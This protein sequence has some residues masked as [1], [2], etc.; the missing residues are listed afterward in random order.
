MAKHISVLDIGTAKTVVIIAEEKKEVEPRRVNVLGFGESKTEGMKNGVIKNPE[1]VFESIKEAL[2]DAEKMADIKI[3]EINVGITSENLKSTSSEGAVALSSKKKA[4][5]AKDIAKVRKAAKTIPLPPDMKIID[6]IDQKYIVD[7][8]DEFEP[9][10]GMNAVRLETVMTLLTIER[11]V[12]ENIHETI[13]KAGL[14]IGNIFS[15]SLCEGLAV[16]DKSE[17]ELG[18][19]VIDIGADTTEA[20]IWSNNKLKETTVI[21][22]AGNSITKDL[23]ICLELPFDQSEKLKVEE[24]HALKDKTEAKEIEIPGIG[25][26]ENRK[27]SKKLM[28]EIIEARVEEILALVKRRVDNLVDID[29]LRAGVILTGGTAL[30]GGM[31]NLTEKVFGLPAKISTPKVNKE[32]DEMLVNPKYAATIGL[33]VA[34]LTQEGEQFELTEQSKVKDL[35]DRIK[36]KFLNRL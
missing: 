5:N 13:S 22:Y 20:S 10:I 3:D 32:F 7:G 12:I 24:G 18:A 11:E 28:A 30:M 25:A 17:K 15:N 4:V 9:P 16:L 36:D 21:K 29:T 34:K 8:N 31:V 26:R 27:V 14:R 35:I 33:V 2:L 23:S 1:K 6:T 19:L